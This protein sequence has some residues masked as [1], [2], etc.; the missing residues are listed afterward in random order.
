MPYM[1]TSPHLIEAEQLVDYLRHPD[2]PLTNNTY[3]PPGEPNVVIWGSP[4]VPSTWVVYAQCASFLTSVLSHTYPSWAT[5]DYFRGYFGSVRPLARD[6]YRVLAAGTA[7]HFSA[8]SRVADL[9]PGDYVAIDYRNG[10]E[11]NTGHLVMVRRVVGTYTSPSSTLNFPGETQYAVEIVDC[12]SDPHGVFGVGD[13]AAFPDTRMVD[14]TNDNDGAGYGHM[15][16]YAANTTGAFTRY[17]WSVNS[18]S[19]NTFPVSQRP[20]AAARIT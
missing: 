15:M 7:P 11:T 1:P 2:C 6:F 16:F 10:Q 5:D 19:A 14:G 3:K 9:L 18:G 13:Y 12:T 17:R 8:V 4:G 20:I